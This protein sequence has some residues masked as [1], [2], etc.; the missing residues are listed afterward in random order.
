MGE[1]QESEYGCVVG[2]GVSK[3]SMEPRELLRSVEEYGLDSCPH[4]KE[5]SLQT[6]RQKGGKACYCY[7]QFPYTLPQHQ[8]IKGP[9]YHCA[10]Q[11][12][13]LFSIT[14]KPKIH[15]DPVCFSEASEEAS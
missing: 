2:V 7:L 4:C 12:R 8:F 1:L 11:L 6:D 9:S 15:S 5:K 3:L 14:T 13:G 10:V